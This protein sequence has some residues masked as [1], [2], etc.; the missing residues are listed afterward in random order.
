MAK[1]PDGPPRIRWRSDTQYHWVSFPD[2]WRV[3]AQ[4]RKAR[5]RDIFIFPGYAGWNGLEGVLSHG[6]DPIRC[7]GAHFCTPALN[8]DADDVLID[9]TEGRGKW[10]ILSK[11]EINQLMRILMA[12]WVLEESGGEHE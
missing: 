10:R 9:R 4:G 8:T 5:E 11:D 2:K 7:C 6:R 12:K 3:V 1:V